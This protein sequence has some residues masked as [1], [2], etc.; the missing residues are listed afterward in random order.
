MKS[1]PEK[2]AIEIKDDK[3][4][5]NHHLLYVISIVVILLIGLIIRFYDL[6]ETPL[7]FHPTRQLYS[8][9]K[10]RGMYYQDLQSAPDWQRE[11][12]VG[13]WQEQGLIEPPVMERLTAFT[14]KILGQELLWVARIYSILFW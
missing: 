11:F 8:A 5:N 10:A 12:A 6:T 13:L 4:F 3:L 14:Y 9:I 7:D 1:V 2:F